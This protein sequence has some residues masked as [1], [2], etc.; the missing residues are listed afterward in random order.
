VTKGHSLY[1]ADVLIPVENLVNHRS[2][3]WDDDARS[4][5]IYHVELDTH[6]VLIADGAPA[7]SY[8]DDG[9]RRLFQ[10]VNPAWDAPAPPPCA[11]IVT[12]GPVVA[13]LWQAMLELAEPGPEFL[14]TDDP[15]LHLLVDGARVVPSTVDGRCY[16]FDLD[17]VG[18]ALRIVSRAAPPAELGLTH[19]QRRLGVA[20]E[21][22]VL[23]QPGMTLDLHAGSP[24]LCDG[25]HMFEADDN[26]RWTDGDAVL[27]AA[28]LAAFAGAPARLELHLGASTSYRRPDALPAVD[29]RPARAA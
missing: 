25:F 24:L 29:E 1:L 17:A 11:P 2:I 8:R 7:E 12:V 20:V 23:R 28:A 5:V 19:E 16:A 27:P 6:D 26:L 21:R 15:D 13:A 14:L 18:A 9:N 3:L 10:N 4:V 22:I